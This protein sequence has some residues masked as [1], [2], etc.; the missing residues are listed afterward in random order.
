MITI[1]VRELKQRMSEVL[2]Q[3][4]R[5]GEIV[6]ITKRGVVIARIVPANEQR[7][8]SSAL[9]DVWTDIDRIAAEISARW[10]EGVS[11][12]DAVN[13]SRRDL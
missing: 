4:D 1:G 2:N 10:P 7:L 3:I 13:E 11:A 5:T 6:E 9:E 12:V 8:V